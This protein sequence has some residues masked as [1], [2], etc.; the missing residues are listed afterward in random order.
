MSRRSRGRPPVH[1]PV[2]EATALTRFLRAV[3]DLPWAQQAVIETYA[4][5]FDWEIER[6]L[7]PACLAAGWVERGER[8]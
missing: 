3:H 7:R 2:T 8:A 6:Q 4:G 1:A 5:L